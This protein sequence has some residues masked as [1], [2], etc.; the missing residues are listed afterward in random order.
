MSTA[1]RDG[2]RPFC[3]A[4]M[5]G[6]IT[7]GVVYP[8]AVCE[9]ARDYRFK[10]LGGASAGAIAAAGAAAAELGRSRG[11]QDGFA[12]LAA[13]PGELGGASTA[14]ITRLFALFQP[15]RETRPLF[16]VCTAALGGGL[17]AVVRVATA[18]VRSFPIAA[19]LGAVPGLWILYTASQQAGAA[20]ALTFLISALVLLVG[21]AVVLAIRFVAK[22]GAA[23]PANGYG[24]CSGMP[25]VGGEPRESLTPWLTGF[26]DEL[27]GVDPNGPPLTF[28]DLANAAE[29]IH[30]E[31][32][33]TCLTLGRPYRLPF[34]DDEEVRAGLFYFHKGEF[35]RL[36]P[37]RVVDWMLAHPRL[38]QDGESL[39]RR[40][41]FAARDLYPLPAANDLPV[42]VAVRMSLSFPILLGAIPLWAIDHT[43]GPN[44]QPERCWF[45]DGGICSNFPVHFFDSP[46][47]R[48]PTFGINLDAKHPRYEA[49]FWM[50]KDNRQGVS[51]RWIRFDAPQGLR[52]IRGFLGSIVGTMMG[53][54]DT[55]QSELP[56]YR[57]RIAHVLLDANDGGLNLNMPKDRIERLSGYGRQAGIELRERFRGRRPDCD[58]DWRNHRWIRL[59]CSL[60]ALE[61]LLRKIERGAAHEGPG[62]GGYEDWL[63]S[64]EDPPSYAWSRRSQRELAAE[65]LAALRA[66]MARIAKDEAAHGKTLVDDSPRPRPELRVRPRV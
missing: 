37:K 46:L 45:S 60:A 51:P 24:L 52:A 47:P 27:A 22:A 21:V 20:R 63:R 4:V 5:K 11:S 58:L 62:D 34:R 50:P 7:S 26:Y 49:G 31:M 57:D 38:A 65:T 14:G 2:E 56:G 35:E 9:L 33:T 10:S 6:G 48:W 39:V 17:G 43:L 18:A 59:R 15:Q 25:G 54:S 8:L 55:T 66:A 12:R 36:F 29:P 64:S 40:D 30:L 32:M 13:L 42:V 23:L 28:G 41:E 61:E 1:I 44:A 3:D 53:W 16:R 19:A